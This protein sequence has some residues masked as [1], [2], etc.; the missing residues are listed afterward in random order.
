[1]ALIVT[2]HLTKLF[3]RGDETIRAI[4]DL[5]ISIE[6]GEFVSIT[7]SSGSGKSTLLYIL[8][9]LDRPTSGRYLLQGSP[10]EGLDD[11]RRAQLRNKFMGFVFQ[12]F[13]LLPRASALRNVMMPLVYV[14]SHSAPLSDAEQSHR[15]RE[16][17]KLVGLSDRENHLPSELSGGQRQRVAIARAIVNNPKL[18]FADEPTGNLDSKSGRDILSLFEKLN[19]QGVTVLMVT[20]D[21]SISERAPRRLVLQ[22]GALLEDRRAR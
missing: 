14:G 12:S 5:S 10:V 16:A 22:D 15:A 21:P 20:H 11:A 17:L 9:L 6:A 18:L 13:H 19:A 8:G 7:G 4:N 3:T 2:E 1:M